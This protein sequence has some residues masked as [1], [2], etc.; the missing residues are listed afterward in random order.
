MRKTL[1]VWGGVALV[2]AIIIPHAARANMLINGGLESDPA[3]LSPYNLIYA[4]PTLNPGALNGWTIGASLDVVPNSYWQAAEGSFSVDLIGSPD[5]DGQSVLGAISQTVTGL[6]VSQ[7]YSLTFEFSVNPENYTGEGGTTKILDVTI[8]NSDQPSTLF[9]ASAGT[10]TDSD[11]QWTGET[12]NFTAS[13]GSTTIT[14]ASE[15]PTNLP[16][17]LT[18]GTVPSATNLYCGP[19][20]DNVDLEVFSGSPTTPEPASLGILGVGSL[21]LIRRRN[22]GKR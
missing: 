17:F 9:S 11:M 12:I 14:F 16:A 8:A 2:S 4:S 18:N 21:L 5:G 13:A 19:V 3:L 15:L 6:T 1:P 20:I 22:T 7:Q 10:R